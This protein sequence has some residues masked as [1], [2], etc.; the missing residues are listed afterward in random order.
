MI[1]WT[2]LEK[3]EILDLLEEKHDMLDFLGTNDMQNILGKRGD[4]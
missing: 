2:S 3:E 1:Y 4:S